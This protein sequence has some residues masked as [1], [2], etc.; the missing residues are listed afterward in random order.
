M[1]DVI[2]IS[3]EPMDSGCGIAIEYTRDVSLG[4]YS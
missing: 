4:N 1:M 2:V 3:G